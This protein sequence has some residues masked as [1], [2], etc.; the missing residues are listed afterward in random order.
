MR[1]FQHKTSYRPYLDTQ[2]RKQIVSDMRDTLILLHKN[3]SFEVFWSDE[4]FWLQMM[5]SALFLAVVCANE[6]R[7]DQCA[8]AADV[9]IDVLVFANGGNVTGADLVHRA[10]IHRNAVFDSQL[11]DQW[12]TALRLAPLTAANDAY[13]VRSRV[14]DVV[15]TAADLRA[16]D[17]LF[18]VPKSEHF[19]WPAVYLGEQHAA[20]RWSSFVAGYTVTVNAIR[21]NDKPLVLRT[22]SVRP[23]IF[24][25]EGFLTDSEAGERR[26]SVSFRFD[27][28][29][30]EIIAAAK[31]L[32]TRSGV[33]ESTGTEQS[34]VRTSST[35]WLFPDVIPISARIEE[36][37]ARLAHTSDLSLFEAMQVVHYD[38]PQKYDAHYG[39]EI[40][41]RVCADVE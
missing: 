37:S 10:A 40:E 39:E 17:Y 22:I 33:A 2:S 27:A 13:T 34:E 16:D 20:F 19:I 1:S 25:I 21:V 41:T 36:R 3:P 11:I 6:C 32:L 8:T 7:G 14:G 18:L 12:A 15:E 31:P 30:D 9:V 23:R 5:I 35:A 29:V 38:G 26:R 4:K 28:R 24:A